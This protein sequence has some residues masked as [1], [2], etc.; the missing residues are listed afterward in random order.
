MGI[1]VND[2]VTVM[3]L[4]GE[5]V[6]KLVSDDAQGVTLDNPRFVTVGEQGMGFAGGIAMTGVEN[7]KSV[8]LKS[9]L[10]VTET[11][12]QVENAYRSA[13]SGII[14][15]QKSSIIT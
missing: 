10:F 5:F 1:A 2:V 7:P 15:P 14:Q 11:N 6:G 13:V 8:C 3:T 4:S 12:P 9:V